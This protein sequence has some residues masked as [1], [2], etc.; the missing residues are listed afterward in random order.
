MISIETQSSDL[1]RQFKELIFLKNIQFLSLLFVLILMLIPMINLYLDM[2][3]EYTL[4]QKF[5]GSI[6]IEISIDRENMNVFIFT[7]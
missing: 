2:V 1:R 5:Q 4:F 7:L 6:W 3:W